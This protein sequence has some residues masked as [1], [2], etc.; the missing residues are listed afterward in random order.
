MKI[1]S[2]PWGN[3]DFL[4]PF[5]K[6]PE[7]YFAHTASHGGVMMPVAVA[8]SRGIKEYGE[9][10]R[11]ADG[12]DWMAYE[13][14]CAQVVPVMA[15]YLRGEMDLTAEQVQTALIVLT[16]T[17]NG[18]LK[19]LRLQDFG[20]NGQ[21]VL[22]TKAAM[23]DVIARID[24]ERELREGEDEMRRRRDP[25]LVVSAI[26]VSDYSELATKLGVDET[27]TE[28]KLLHTE[29]RKRLAFVKDED[30]ST[31]FGNGSVTLVYTAD[32]QSH[33]VRKYEVRTPNILSSCSILALCR[34]CK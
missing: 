32:G 2:S 18:Y 34:M 30:S 17:N 13:E 14:D 4:D 1:Q 8:E 25:D 11:T 5:C 21:R 7:V 6:V 28:L 19:S 27:I 23:A 22:D 9:L 31:L 10:F 29:L 3:V 12:L 16:S 15:F 24:G 20:D 26:S 33:L